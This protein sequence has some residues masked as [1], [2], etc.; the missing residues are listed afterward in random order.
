VAGM[1]GQ[2]GCARLDPVSLSLSLA[3][4]FSPVEKVT[5]PSSETV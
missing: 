3:A 1:G 5:V 2:V 4:G